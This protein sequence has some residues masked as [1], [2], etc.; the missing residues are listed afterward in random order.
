MATFGERLKLL[1]HERNLSLDM[2]AEK[3]KNNKGYIEQ[4]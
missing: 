1:R 3:I 2:L 4:I